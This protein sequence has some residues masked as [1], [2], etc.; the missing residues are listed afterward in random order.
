MAAKIHFAHV[1]HTS[2]QPTS[3]PGI[4]AK[5]LLPQTSGASHNL[6]LV[7]YEAG[8]VVEMHA[9]H[10]PESI[11][12][13]DGQ[14]QVKTP[15]GEIILGPDDAVHFDPGTEHGMQ[16]LDGPAR[17]LVMFTPIPDTAE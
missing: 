3:R 8:A 10:A 9:T 12:V 13:L 17:C 15:Q 14:V 2:W 5:A 16:T 11:F 7:E 1:E 4:R 6:I